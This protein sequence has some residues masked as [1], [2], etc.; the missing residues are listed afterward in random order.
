ML[1]QDAFDGKDLLCSAYP[2][3]RYIPILMII[4]DFK[5]ITVRFDHFSCFELFQ[6]HPIFL[7]KEAIT[8]LVACQP[9]AQFL[10]C[11]SRHLLFWRRTRFKHVQDIEQSVGKFNL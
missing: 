2:V 10:L 8:E 9:A 5:R 4:L 6:G 7:P 11:K 1:L 3:N